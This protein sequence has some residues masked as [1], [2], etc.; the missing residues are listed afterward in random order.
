MKIL[1]CIISLIILISGCALER[2]NPLDPVEN[3]IKVPNEVI[4]I[5]V[6]YNSSDE[7]SIS[8]LAQDDADGYYIYRC[9]SIDGYYQRI[10]DNLLNSELIDSFIDDEIIPGTWYYYKMSA[11]IVIDGKKL[12]GWRSGPK[13]W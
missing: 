1:I 5:S 7:I 11:Y 12:E 9:Q 8:W 13:T 6:S 2:S 3:D 4:G 10:D